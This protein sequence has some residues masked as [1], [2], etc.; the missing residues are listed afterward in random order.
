[1][2]EITEVRPGAARE[3]LAAVR[4]QRVPLLR[5]YGHAIT[6]LYEVLFTDNEVVTVWATDPVAHVALQRAQSTDARLR[7]WRETA[8]G[9]VVRTRE[10]LMTPHPDIPIGPVPDD[11]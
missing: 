11:L 5:G 2:H 8:R 4:E 10:E 6:G 1:M 9:Y 7:A 3:Y